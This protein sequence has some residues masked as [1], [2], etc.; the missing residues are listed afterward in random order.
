MYPEDIVI[1]NSRIWAIHLF[2]NQ[3]V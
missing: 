2:L 1:D 3:E